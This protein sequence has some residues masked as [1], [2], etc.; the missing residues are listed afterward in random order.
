MNQKKRYILIVILLGILTV[1][2]ISYA[3]WQLTKIQTGENIVTSGCF[4]IEMKGKNDISLQNAYPISDEEGEKLTPYEFTVT[5]KCNNYAAY[6]V[7]LEELITEPKRLSH[8]YIK[9]EIENKISSL[10]DLKKVTPTI[11]TSDCSHEIAKGILD[12][13]EEKTYTLKLWMDEDTPALEEVMDA[14]FLSKVTIT[15]TYQRDIIIPYLDNVKA[16]NLPTKEDKYAFEK[17]EC[18]NNIKLNWNNNAWS[19]TLKNIPTTGAQ[20]VCK[21][22]FK[23]I[24]YEVVFYSETATFEN[25][26]V[27]TNLIQNGSFENEYND[28]TYAN[29]KYNINKI[30][31]SKSVSGSKSLYINDT[32]TNDGFWLRQKFLQNYKLG[33]ILYQGTF[34]HILNNSNNALQVILGYGNIDMSQSFDGIV[35]SMYYPNSSTNFKKLSLYYQV[36]TEKP[37]IL[38]IGSS[39][40]GLSEVYYDGI[41]V[42]NLTDTFGRGNEPTREWLDQYIPYFETTANILVESIEKLETKKFQYV[43]EKEAKVDCIN[44]DASL[45]NGFLELSNAIGDVYCRFE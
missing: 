21:I 2:G 41:Y 26:K 22:Y 20:N 8:D 28:W 13:N 35:A 29:S 10:K 43:L 31:S 33:D 1:T 12:P 45:S 14:N 17:A 24:N 44:A 40:S 16:L 19:Y 38:Q 9:I 25:N 3:V 18:N 5:N 7:N 34:A 23:T 30:V 4:K 37:I 6:Q 36:N 15:S 39:I 32:K 27:I 11:N 42:I